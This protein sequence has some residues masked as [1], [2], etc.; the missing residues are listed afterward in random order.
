MDNLETH[1]ERSRDPLDVLLIE[2]GVYLEKFGHPFGSGRLR[3][4]DAA[5]VTGE[6]QERLVKI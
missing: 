3:G 5:R 1:D 6:M 4:D 2:P